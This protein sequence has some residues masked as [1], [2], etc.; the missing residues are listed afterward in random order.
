[1]TLRSSTPDLV[2]AVFGGRT[3]ERSGRAREIDGAA[4]CGHNDHMRIAGGRH[5]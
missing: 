1:M 2:D 4:L 5:R 3:R